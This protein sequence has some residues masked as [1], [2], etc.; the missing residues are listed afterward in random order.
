MLCV[1]VPQMNPGLTCAQTRLML[2]QGALPL[3]EWGWTLIL[4]GSA[5]GLL[6]VLFAAAKSYSLQ[7]GVGE[8]E[9]MG[10]HRYDQLGVPGGDQTPDA[11]VRDGGS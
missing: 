4:I 7:E 11:L 1:C 6:S 10:T 9:Q 2:R 3:P 5:L 8:P